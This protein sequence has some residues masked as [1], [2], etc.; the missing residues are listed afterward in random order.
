MNEQLMQ[1]LSLG[2]FYKTKWKQGTAINDIATSE[3]CG[4]RK[5]QKYLSLTMLSPKIIEDIMNYKNPKNF[6]LTKL[7]DMSQSIENFSEQEKLWYVL[8]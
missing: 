5:V 3:H 2:W 8:N 6:T 7:M 4:K 1:G